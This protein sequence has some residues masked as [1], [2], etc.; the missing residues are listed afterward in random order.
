[1]ASEI[2]HV[3]LNVFFLRE[4]GM[5]NRKGI[6]GDEKFCRSV[7]LIPRNAANDEK[8]K[9]EHDK[10]ICLITV[11]SELQSLLLHCWHF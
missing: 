3:R 10:D 2:I 4:G 11:I 9:K 8:C 6:S 1:M 7:P 5:T